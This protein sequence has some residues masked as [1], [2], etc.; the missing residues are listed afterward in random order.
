MTPK[1]LR[2]VQPV[3]FH[4]DPEIHSKFE[5]QL[6]PRAISKKDALNEAMFMWTHLGRDTELL[7]KLKKIT[8]EME[9]GETE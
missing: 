3:N 4:A 5:E 6:K 9:E 2:G 8:K 7:E 1:K